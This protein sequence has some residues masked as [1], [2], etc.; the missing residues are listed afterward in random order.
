[1]HPFS[2][3]ESFD[4]D[5]I[6]RM[7]DSALSLEEQ[8]ELLDSFDRHPDGWRQ[9]ALAYMES[10][11]LKSDFSGMLP[12]PVGPVVDVI[13]EPSVEPARVSGGGGSSSDWIITATIAVAAFAVGMVTLSWW[14]GRGADSDIPPIAGSYD[15]HKDPMGHADKR[16]HEDADPDFLSLTMPAFGHHEPDAGG[17][18]RLRIPLQKIAPEMTGRVYRAPPVISP[19]LRIKLRRQGHIVREERRVYP[20]KLHDGRQVLV[21]VNEIQ[22]FYVG[23]RVF[24]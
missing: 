7:V 21:P 13:A 5:A 12:A 6:D 10:Q 9:L 17:Q 11:T 15:E 4:R 24:Q 22:I 3:A 19:E 23:N 14:R 20:V 8:R 16:D 2:D 1:M 18:R